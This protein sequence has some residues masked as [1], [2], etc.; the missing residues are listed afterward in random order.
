MK[1]FKQEF[2]KSFGSLEEF[3]CNPENHHL[4]KDLNIA[5]AIRIYLKVHE[6][7]QKEIE[8]IYTH[9]ND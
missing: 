4:W 7:L 5:P 8:K 9:E 1:N 2:E 3:F 6:E